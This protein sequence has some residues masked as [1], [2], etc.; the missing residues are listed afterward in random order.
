[1]LRSYFSKFLIIIGLL[2]FLYPTASK[3]FYEQRQ[4]NIKAS[5]EQ[6]IL[7]INEVDRGELENNNLDGDILASEPQK[8]TTKISPAAKT[9]GILIIEK[10]NLSLPILQGATA[11][12]L[13]ISVASIDYTAKAGQY[14]NHVI[15]GHR[16]HSY[17]RLFN[18]LE[19][20]DVGDLIQV[21][22]KGGVFTY[23][24]TEKLFV[25]PEEIWVMEGSRDKKEISLIT[26]HPMINPTLRLVIKGELLV[27][28][29]T[30][31]RID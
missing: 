14:G 4:K 13:N 15:T 8:T 7:A 18:R 5:W 3:L 31:R 17:G 12:N 29:R 1:L 24:V 2:I 21:E 20:L 28:E 11:K 30:E 9:E 27:D 23:Q 19:E 16:S 26:C 6:S 22:Q 25:K 10:I